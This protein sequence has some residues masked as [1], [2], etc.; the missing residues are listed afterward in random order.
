MHAPDKKNSKRSQNC[1]PIS[2]FIRLWTCF[3]PRIYR[4]I[5]LF[6]NTIKFFIGILLLLD[7]EAE[8][9]ASTSSSLLSLSL[10]SR[11]LLGPDS[12][13]YRLVA[14][15]LSDNIAANSSL[16]SWSPRSRW[17]QRLVVLPLY[18]TVVLHKQQTA[19]S[20]SSTLS[21]S[22]NFHIALVFFISH[23]YLN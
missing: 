15:C 22:K 7:D 23:N 12:A 8:V 18:G 2:H 1:F 13:L 5:F 17:N 4:F 21:N 6:S 9:F 11:S 20:F 3:S 14:G 19:T 10:P 16:C